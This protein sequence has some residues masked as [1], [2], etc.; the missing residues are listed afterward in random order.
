M[1]PATVSVWCFHL[2]PLTPSLVVAALFCLFRSS[3]CFAFVVLLMAVP[4]PAH[5][6]TSPRDAATTPR[7]F[8]DRVHKSRWFLQCGVHQQ[9][10][11]VLELS[12][13]RRVP[14]GRRGAA[15]TRTLSGCPDHIYYVFPDDSADQIRTFT[16]HCHE[17]VTLNE[18]G[19]ETIDDTMILFRNFM[20]LSSS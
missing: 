11:L 18:Q 14:S 16:S 2:T 13:R 19:T 6:S 8:A 5:R 7:C 17:P 20:L 12:G 10:V 3:S 15:Q 4:D 1:R 9:L